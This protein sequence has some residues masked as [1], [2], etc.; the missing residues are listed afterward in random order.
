MHTAMLADPGHRY[1][2]EV[3]WTE[4]Q[5][6]IEAAGY[7]LR[8]RY[9]ED[10][11]FSGYRWK[12]PHKWFED[13]QRNELMVVLKK[14]SDAHPPDELEISKLFS[15][16]KYRQN[17][18]NHCI[19]LLELMRLEDSEASLLVLPRMRPYNNPIQDVRRGRG[20]RHANS[21]GP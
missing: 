7:M 9:H 12:L 15:S 6:D 13:W 1:P 18:K 14:L 20:V 11:K 4:N 10:R 5:K 16:E 17:L 21:R 2:D 3:D 19:P 8:P